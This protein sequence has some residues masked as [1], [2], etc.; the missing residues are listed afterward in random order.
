LPRKISRAWVIRSWLLM[1][2]TA[3]ICVSFFDGFL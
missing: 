2:L 1:L 3:I